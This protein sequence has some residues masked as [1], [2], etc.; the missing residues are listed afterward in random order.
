MSIIGVIAL[1]IANLVIFLV[2]TTI[3]SSLTFGDRS[4]Y[5]LFGGKISFRVDNDGESSFAITIYG[6]SQT[7][8][9]LSSSDLI[10]PS[11][12]TNIPGGNIRFNET[13]P[14]YT[15]P[16]I[17]KSVPTLVQ[18]RIDGQHPGLYSG[19]MNVEG[20]YPVSIPLLLDV[21][22]NLAQLF[23]VVVD[24][25]AASIAIWKLVKYLNGIIVIKDAALAGKIQL[26][27]RNNWRGKPKDDL[28]TMYIEEKNITKGTVIKDLVLNAF[29]I[30]F[31]ILVG[32]FALFN[33]DFFTGIRILGPYEILLLF[34]VGL[35]IGSLKEY[36]F[37]K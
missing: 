11:P 12:N 17:S 9:T 33:E 23:I 35:G 4:V 27:Q 15:V 10:G 32:V 28:L 26:K 14:P 3:T 22:T 19:A 29:S 21:K 30:F 24:G 16:S 5:S 31:G 1:I 18:I 6:I 2:A 34:V 36:V 20:D 37:E 13:S 8:V 7:P 25:I